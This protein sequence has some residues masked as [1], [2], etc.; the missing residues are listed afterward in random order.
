ML[1]WCHKML[2]PRTK[3]IVL[4]DISG[5]IAKARWTMF[6]Y[7]FNHHSFSMPTYVYI[8]TISINKHRWYDVVPFIVVKIKGIISS[9][10]YIAYKA[11]WI[12]Q[13][14]PWRSLLYILGIKSAHCQAFDFFVIGSLDF[15]RLNTL[16]YSSVMNIIKFSSKHNA[17]V[18]SSL[19][20]V[21]S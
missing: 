1:Y 2:L 3:L 17:L 12:E 4:I 13:I 20:Q 9:V 16:W 18:Q 14:N 21:A 11:I 15:S 5:K 10:M 8:N 7:H 6:A 19:T